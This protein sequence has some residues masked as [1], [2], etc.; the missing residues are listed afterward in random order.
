MKY[1]RTNHVYKIKNYLKNI[2]NNSIKNLQQQN[3]KLVN[4]LNIYKNKV[5]TRNKVYLNQIDF[6]TNVMLTCSLI[7]VGINFFI[8]DKQ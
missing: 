3:N 4:D 1:L 6:I 8:L 7:S 5:E 2:N